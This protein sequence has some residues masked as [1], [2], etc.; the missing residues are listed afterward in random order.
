MLDGERVLRWFAG[1]LL[2]RYHYLFL[3]TVRGDGTPNL[4]RVPYVWDSASAY[5]LVETAIAAEAAL[6][7][8]GTVAG[9]VTASDGQPAVQ[10]RGAIAPVADQADRARILAQ[11]PTG[12]G[13]AQPRGQLTGSRPLNCG[14]VPISSPFTRP[15]R[16]KRLSNRAICPTASMSSWLVTVRS[17]RAA[18]SRQVVATLTTGAYF[19]ETGLLAGVPRT[20]SVIATSETQLL[21]L[22]RAAFQAALGDTAST[23]EELA[24]VIS[25]EARRG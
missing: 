2:Q 25:A 15:A 6:D 3:A 12:R 22:S 23:A 9:L 11:L 16:A 17:P 20:A 10:L 4:L 24:R 18:G 13:V 8:A 14:P 21:G 19:G 7:A 1:T 5:I